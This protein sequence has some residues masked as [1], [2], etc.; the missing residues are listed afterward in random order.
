MHA[1]RGFGEVDIH[2][3]CYDYCHMQLS[4]ALLIVG[5][6]AIYTFWRYLESSVGSRYVEAGRIVEGFFD[7]IQVRQT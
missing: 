3:P 1:C 4:M 7:V 2:V 5:G 6:V